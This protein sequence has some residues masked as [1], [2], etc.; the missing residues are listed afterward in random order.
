MLY[1]HAVRQRE[2]DAVTRALGGEERHEDALAGF[3]RNGL[4]VVTDKERAVSILQTDTGSSGLDGVLHQID[5]DLTVCVLDVVLAVQPQHFA[6]ILAISDKVLQNLIHGQTAVVYA[7]AVN[8][9]STVRRADG[10]AHG[11]RLRK[12]A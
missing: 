1:H 7:D 2:T 12:G 5:V 9:H 6:D 11:R 10:D 8:I 3:C 4:P